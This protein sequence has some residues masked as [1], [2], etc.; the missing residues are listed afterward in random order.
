MKLAFGKAIILGVAMAAASL[1]GCS[2]DHARSNS[3]A[4]SKE[5]I[6]DLGLQLQVG[7][8]TVNSV[9]YVLT[10]GTNTYTG[11][12]NVADAGTLTAVIGGVIAG[13]GYTLT[14]TATAT[15]GT[16]QCSGSASAITVTANQ[17]AVVGIELRCTK[18]RNKGSVLIDGT[19]NECPDITA[20]VGDA[21]DS[22]AIGLHVT[23]T[24]DGKP[25]PPG[26]LSYTWTGAPGLAGAN[27]VLNCAA[28]GLVTLSVTVSDGDVDPTCA[29]TFGVVVRCPANC[30]LVAPT[31]ADGIQNQN[32]S[33]IDC[34]GVCGS[35]CALGKKC[36]VTGDCAGPNT[37]QNGT[38][39][40]PVVCANQ[41]LQCGGPCPP[42][43]VTTA[44][45]IATKDPVGTT[46][47]TDC[48]IANCSND[49]QN[50]NC[51]SIAGN[52][53]TGPATGQSKKSLCLN[54]LQC[55][56]AS[57]PPCGAVSAAN[58]YC[59]PGGGAACFTTGATNNGACLSD[60]QKG[61]E[62]T[63]PPIIQSRYQTSTFGGGRANKL[64]QCLKNNGCT[65]CL[66]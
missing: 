60:E 31:C 52:A 2:S 30:P 14:L 59:G 29:E 40:G 27:T 11:D 21:P 32:E 51:D 5:N 47:C 25:T 15:D 46:D 33:D 35:S 62:D 18:V 1:G 54:L 38:C 24:D 36:G 43:P 20:V 50:L 55:E 28:G 39:Q 12:I 3:S 64:I 41:A 26:A 22:C 45:L 6:G 61:L 23:A 7:D 56:L 17:T 13:T 63:S 9:H 16:S 42:C 57:V 49:F 48:A 44:S 10:N 19:V 37:C 4:A 66:Q 58:C 65:V 8:L 34:G 53:A